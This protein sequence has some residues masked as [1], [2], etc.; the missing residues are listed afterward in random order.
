MVLAGGV[1]GGGG[2]AGDVGAGGAGVGNGFLYKNV[3]KVTV[4]YQGIT[5]RV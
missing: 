4:M 3:I 1:A 2:G 5:A